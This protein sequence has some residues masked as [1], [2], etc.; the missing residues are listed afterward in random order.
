VHNA[1]PR[2]D[3]NSKDRVRSS[4]LR[5]LFEV[6]DVYEPTAE[7]LAAP[8][9][10]P[11]PKANDLEATLELPDDD[12][13]EAYFATTSLMNDLSR[14]RAEVAELW[15]R[16]HAGQLDLATVSVATNAAIDLA[17]SLEAEIHPVLKY[18]TETQPWHEIYLLQSVT[19]PALMSYRERIT[20]SRPTISRMPS[21]SMLATPSQ[22]FSRITLREIWRIATANGIDSMSVRA[23]RL[24]PIRRSIS[25]TN[26]TAGN[27]AAPAASLQPSGSL[28]R[29][30]GTW[31]CRGSEDA[32]ASRL[33]TAANLVLFRCATIPRHPLLHPGTRP[34]SRDTSQLLTNGLGRRRME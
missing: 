5:N 11:P 32:Q 2:S 20:T 29:T 21:L 12:I 25:A 19:P 23:A 30:I 1:V 10:A 28:R 9:A 13:F 22:Y 7:F 17:H 3:A 31:I 33:E 26:Q 4:P 14:L 6:L 8:D 16:H 15:A 27:A 18:I 34:S 24:H